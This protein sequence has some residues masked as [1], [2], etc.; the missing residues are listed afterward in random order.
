MS[1]VKVYAHRGASGYALE[2]TWKSFQK[3]CNFGVGIELDV[4]I[5]KDGVIVVFHDDNVKRLSGKDARIEE[6]DYDFLKELKIG[7]KWRRS[8]VH[9][10]I[11]LA[12]EVFQ[13]AKEKKVPLNIEMKSSFLHHPNGTK[14]LCAM[15]DGLHD[16]H[17][18]SFHPQLLKE[19]KKTKPSV[20]T[21][22]I[23]KKKF[24]LEEVIGM[25]WVD[26]L[27]LHKRLYSSQLIDQLQQT[28]KKIRVYGMVG[29]E[30]AIKKPDSCLVGVITDY[31]DRIK[32]KLRPA[33]ER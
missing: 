8:F 3:A 20:E 2:N 23:L 24:S 33:V 30:A 32:E 18:S 6:V 15:L 9:H 28:G 7:K 29:S 17:L 14:I 5:T 10:K 25:D 19:I 26:S 31:P 13:W 1:E 21:A 16:V 27:H 12:Y 4:Q 22:L 11:P